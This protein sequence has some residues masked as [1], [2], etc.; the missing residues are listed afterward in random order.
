MSFLAQ[1]KIFPRNYKWL[2][3]LS[4][5]VTLCLSLPFSQADEDTELRL[6]QRN[7][8]TD[9]RREKALLKDELD[10]PGDEAQLVINGQ[11]YRA[12]NNLNSL[13]QA[14]YLSV[15]HQQWHA[16]DGFLQRYLA[17]P[18]HDSM[19]VHYAQGAL[20]RSR[21][22]LVAAE[23]E[24]RALLRLQPNFL[25]GQLEL[26]RVLFENHK[27]RDSMQLFSEI[28]KRIPSAEIRA[29]G[30]RNTINSFIEALNYR[31]SWRGSISIGAS[32][33]DNLNQS[34]ESYTCFLRT[35]DNQCLIERRAPEAKSV[36]GSDFDASLNKRMSFGNHHGLHFSALMYGNTYKEHKTFNE[37]IA[38]AKLGY[39][40]HSAKNQYYAAPLFEYRSL[41]ND[42]LYSA[43]GGHLEWRHN[44]SSN[45]A[46]K[47]ETA[48]KDLRYDSGVYFFETG[49]L[50]SA[51]A[52]WWHQWSDQWLVFAGLDYAIKDNSERVN[53]HTAKGVRLGVSRT[54]WTGVEATLFSS[55][56]RREYGAYSALLGERRLDREQNH[57]LIINVPRFQFYDIS[58]S[59]TLQYNRV[60]SNVQWL[61]SYE[62]HSI[63]L[64][65]EKRF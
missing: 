5:I 44:L 29:Q 50:S 23:R 52:T 14:L 49:A 3:P 61:Y 39:S 38:I 8:L 27:N 13:G 63:S 40:Y 35:P 59:I 11:I 2:T 65:F 6:Q 58:P 43:W 42:K 55:L 19:L 16:A 25:P 12:E 17:L 53:A 64:M 51:F 57:T 1:E 10:A 7:T 54:L 20:A 15:Q 45:S 41:S 32:Y 48:Y 36:S 60:D 22:Q 9:Q 30:V 34:S 62:K 46:F 47:L 31:D 24:Y 18:G 37:S 56:R 26:A 21:G 33:T 28:E 4:I